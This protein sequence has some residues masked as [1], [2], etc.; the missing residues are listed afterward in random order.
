MHANSSLEA[1]RHLP[2]LGFATVICL[3][4]LGYRHHQ[5]LGLALRSCQSKRTAD[6]M[7]EP[8]QGTTMPLSRKPASPLRYFNSSAEFIRLVV[9]MYFR[10]L[11]SLWNVE[12]LLAERGIEFCN[13][14]VRHRW[15]RFDPLSVRRSK[16]LRPARKT[17]HNAG[18]SDVRHA[19][20]R[21]GC[22]P[23]R[24]QPDRAAACRLRRAPLV[25]PCV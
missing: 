19:S 21:P 20:L 9:M 2:C 15:N 14:I 11:L 6:E 16:T 13:G 4:S 1:G 8:G 7:P 3:L 25:R 12:D 10:F 24:N 18:G 17:A 22:R 23:C 5:H